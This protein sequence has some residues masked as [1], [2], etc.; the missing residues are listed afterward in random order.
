MFS[1]VCPRPVTF[2]TIQAT[3]DFDDQLLCQRFLS[4]CNGLV[5]IVDSDIDPDA[6]YAESI[7]KFWAI[8][9][10][11][12]RRCP[13]DPTLLPRLAGP[14]ANLALLSLRPELGPDLRIPLPTIEALVIMCTWH[15]SFMKSHTR[16]FYFALSGVIVHLAL[17][18][19]IHQCRKIDGSNFFDATPSFT[20][21]RSRAILWSHT[22]IVNNR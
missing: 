4:C 12:S 13:E 19:G 18:F 20:D 5:S 8:V 22:M 10:V 3:Q 11:G 2:Y 21:A 15:F 9:A 1:Q 17:Q 14:V 16:S 6:T 7:L